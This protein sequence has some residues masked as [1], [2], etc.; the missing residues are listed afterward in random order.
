MKPV[1]FLCVFLGSCTAYTVTRNVQQFACN[2]RVVWQCEYR[3]PPFF[4]DET[5]AYCD[6]HEDC[7]KICNEKR[8]KRFGGR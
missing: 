1:I 7:E 5:L 4:Y 3:T 6:N 2:E 8:D